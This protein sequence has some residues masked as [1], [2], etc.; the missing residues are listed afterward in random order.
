M[1]AARANW[2]TAAR[3]AARSG[4]RCGPR[5]NARGSPA[6][7]RVPEPV[8]VSVVHRQR[9]G[10]GRPP[11]ARSTLLLVAR[12]PLHLGRVCTLLMQLIE[13]RRTRVA[14]L[15]GARS[16]GCQGKLKKFG[17]SALQGS[18]RGSLQDGASS[19][20]KT[21]SQ[22]TSKGRCMPARPPVRRAHTAALRQVPWRAPQWAA[23]RT[24]LGPRRH[25]NSRAR[26]SLDMGR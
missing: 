17:Q 22:T 4:G 10:A 8:C 2:A 6:I 7:G 21:V 13:P 18:A 25:L 12:G 20:G 5:S 1:H 9:H 14:G 23:F 11:V 16:R 15:H 24:A 26:G 3:D 19:F